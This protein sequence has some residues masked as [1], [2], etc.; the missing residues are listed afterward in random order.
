MTTAEGTQGS[1]HQ[2]SDMGPSLYPPPIGATQDTLEANFEDWSRLFSTPNQHA[3]PTF[4]TPVATGRPGRDVGPPDRHTY[5]TDHVHAQ[6]K[7]G[8]HGRGG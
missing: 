6:R 4:Q 7:R 1:H 5:P 3:D 8:R 2:L